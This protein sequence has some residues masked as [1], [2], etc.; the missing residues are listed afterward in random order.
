MKKNPPVQGSGPQAE[1]AAQAQQGRRF[2]YALGKSFL[3]PEPGAERHQAWQAALSEL[4][5]VNFAPFDQALDQLRQR[6]S[7]TSL[8][9]LEEEL[10]RLFFDPFS[11]ENIPLEASFYLDGKPFG[12]SLARLRAFLQEVGLTKAEQVKEPEDHL[13][14]LLDFM[15]TM[16][17]AAQPLHLQK[18]L[19][20]RF[21]RPCL[22]GVAQRVARTQAPFYQ[23]LFAFLEAF[24]TLEERFFQEET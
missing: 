4:P 11:G 3:L 15:E 13:V 18:K 8:P 22:L 20:E 9:A 7:E 10:Y 12:P 1:E 2:I 5:Y 24:L 17:E 16:I 23:A 6:F 14:L 19:F 21:L